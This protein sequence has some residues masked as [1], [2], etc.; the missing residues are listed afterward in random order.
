MILEA[1][2]DEI[3]EGEVAREQVRFYLIAHEHFQKTRGK[4]ERYR[5]PTEQSSK[6]EEG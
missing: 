6:K 5:L 3:H 2:E 4:R 1:V